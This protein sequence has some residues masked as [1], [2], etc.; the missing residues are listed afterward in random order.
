MFGWNVLGAFVIIIWAAAVLG[1]VF[2]FLKFCKVLN[3]KESDF[4]VGLDKLY[5]KQKGSASAVVMSRSKTVARSHAPSGGST[6][7]RWV[8]FDRQNY[9]IYFYFLRIDICKDFY[10]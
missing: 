1:L 10:L 3:I 9:Y 4:E 7:G 6:I 8:L 5:H 2:G